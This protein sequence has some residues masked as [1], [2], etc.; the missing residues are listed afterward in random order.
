MF[1]LSFMLMSDFILSLLFKANEIFG[2]DKFPESVSNFVIV[3]D[4]F[5]IHC[6]FLGPGLLE[7]KA[8]FGLAD[9]I[10]SSA[11]STF[12][13]FYLLT[14]SEIFLPLQL[15]FFLYQGPFLQ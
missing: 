13:L 4:F 3:S 8:A 12:W 2:S 15:F 10:F 6:F 7:N 11:I 14:S 9:C 5:F 1:D